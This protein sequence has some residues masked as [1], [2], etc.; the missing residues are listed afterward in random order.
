MLGYL[1]RTVPVIVRA[2]VRAR[3]EKISRLAR[4][5]WPH[6][7]D[8]NRHMNQSVYAQVMELGRVDWILRSGA[9]DRWQAASVKPLVAEQHIV[10]RRELG[11]FARYTIDTRLVAVEGRLA[12]FSHLLLFGDG[13]IGARVAARGVVK[14][15]FVGSGGVLPADAVPVLCEGLFAPEIQIADWRVA[16]ASTKIPQAAGT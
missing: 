2:R 8:L 11:P 5:V 10:Y 1:S 15:L 13:E 6:E 9:W 3:G 12:V 4:R 16:P 7:V 14:F